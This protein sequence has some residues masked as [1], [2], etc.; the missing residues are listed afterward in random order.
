MIGGITAEREKV[1]AKAA[2]A[3]IEKTQTAEFEAKV[4]EAAQKAEAELVKAKPI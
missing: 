4:N 3:E 1:G 2:D